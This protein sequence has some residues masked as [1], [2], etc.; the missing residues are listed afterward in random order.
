M[1]IAN[2]T[3]INKKMIPWDT[4]WAKHLFA[5]GDLLLNFNSRNGSNLV[6][7]ISAEMAIILT[8]CYINSGGSSRIVGLKTRSQEKWFDGN[9]YTLYFQFRQVGLVSTTT[10]PTIRLGGGTAAGNRGITFEAASGIFRIYMADGATRHYNT[11]VSDPDTSLYNQGIFEVWMQVD[12]TNKL[13]NCKVYN[14]AGAQVGSTVAQ[15]IA[16]F[17][18][19]TN[20]N[21][22]DYWFDS[23]KYIVSNFKKFSSLLTIAQCRTDS[24]RTN[25]L[26][27]Y[28]SIYAA[29]DI[30]GNGLDLNHI[31]TISGDK[32]YY[33]TN[34]WFLDYGCD[35]YISGYGEITRLIARDTSGNKYIPSRE[36]GGYYVA[37]RLSW[38]NNAGDQLLSLQ[39][40][41]I[42]F[43]NAF[44]DRSNATIWNATCRAASDYDAARPKKFHISSL[45]QRTLYNWLN[46]GYKARLFVHW[47]DNSIEKYDRKKLIN[48]YLYNN[49]KKGGDD[50]KIHRYTGDDIAWVLDENNK[51]TLDDDGYTKLGYLKTTKPMFTIRID[52]AYDNCYDHWRPFYN[53]LGIHP[54]INYHTDLAG[55]SAYG[56]NFMSYTRL[57]TLHGEGWEITI[58]NADDDDYN[59]DLDKVDLADS[60]IAQA[61]IDAAD[62]NFVIK[63]YIPNKHST[64][65]VG[66][67]Y[68]SHKHG[69]WMGACGLNTAVL[70]G[71]I[72][73]NPLAIDPYLLYGTPGDLVG[74]PVSYNIDQVVYET[75]M[76]NLKGLVDIC[77]AQNRWLVFFHHSWVAKLEEHMPEFINYCLNAGLTLVNYEEGLENCKYL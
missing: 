69:L 74:L 33:Q 6:D 39:D 34:N 61:K 13:V 21:T 12:F 62:N 41:A 25:L 53:N 67:P 55:T 29:A 28:P 46:D 9:D 52:D 73:V 75:Q 54:T 77:I 42:L 16:D 22:A 49:D 47:D 3:I 18:F 48:I 24:Y 11:L 35:E 32:V 36:A 7:S 17:V 38:E 40:C 44:F 43:T 19:N 59:S 30:S 65:N 37:S 27:H 63:T 50:A 10:Y 20:N 51:R 70:P 72:G 2:T 66:L 57:H 45:N 58:T 23:Q 56:Y 1:I 31:S 14:S 8:P 26:L 5:Q 60:L 71:V 15:T 4:Q 68:L 64:E 76:A